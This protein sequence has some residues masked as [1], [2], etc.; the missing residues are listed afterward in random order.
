DA[1]TLSNLDWDDPRRMPP[2]YR[3]DFRIIDESADMPRAL[4]MVRGDLDARVRDRLRE[5]LAEAGAD[6]DAREALLRFFGTTRFLP[7]DAATTASLRELLA[8]VPRVRQ[9]AD[10]TCAG[11]CAACR[12]SSS[13]RPVSPCC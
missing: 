11:G 4:E 13:A 9:E 8:G 6:P 3:A 2:P 7:I 10:C 12:R 1:G 5:V